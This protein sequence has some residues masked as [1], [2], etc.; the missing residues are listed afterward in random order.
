MTKAA[1]AHMGKVAELG[2]WVCRKVGYGPTPAQVHH[3]RA[4]QG[5]AQRGS[6]W[7]TIP[8]CERHH[9]N[10]S[11]DGVHGGR[12]VWMLHGLDEI[13]ALADTIA[14]VYG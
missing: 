10:H 9:S 4:G 14:A 12:R 11:P 1:K 5:M 2:C 7:L 3:L 13:D 8:L 6:D